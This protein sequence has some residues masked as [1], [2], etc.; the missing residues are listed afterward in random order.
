MSDF[1]YLSYQ[2][3]RDYD[4]L[5]TLNG[6]PLLNGRA[7]GRIVNQAIL[8]E[9]LVVDRNQLCFVF[10]DAGDEI[11]GAGTLLTS[12]IKV[13]HHGQIVTPDGGTLVTLWRQPAS[14]QPGPLPN[15]RE[16]VRPSAR[17]GFR[18]CYRFDNRDYDFSAR[19]RA[20]AVGVPEAQLVDYALHLVNLF[21]RGDVGAFLDE[22]AYKTADLAVA[23]GRHT[24]EVQHEVYELVSKAMRDGLAHTPAREDILVRSWCD[25][26]IYELAIKPG[27]SLITTIAGDEG[28]MDVPI[29]VTLIEHR[30]RIIR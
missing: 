1:Y 20:P 2:V 9:Y 15:I 17:E 14:E 16:I 7:H 22:Y 13:F 24:Q 28:A 29:F 10:P 26:R 23:Y 18:L 25:G 5:V 6:F 11:G 30:L 4:L 3:D 8:N 27:R 12:Q 21:L 19:L